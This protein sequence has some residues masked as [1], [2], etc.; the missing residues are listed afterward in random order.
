MTRSYRP[1][2]YHGYSY[3]SIFANRLGWFL[4][5]RLFCRTGWHLWDEVWSL[6]FHGLFC[7][8]CEIEEE[9]KDA[10]DV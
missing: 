9:I 4:W 1:Y 5:K 2:T 6:D 7:D 3:P 8:A 10:A